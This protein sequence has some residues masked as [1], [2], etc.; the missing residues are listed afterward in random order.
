MEIE[1]IYRNYHDKVYSYIRSRVNS[2]EDAEDICSNVFLKIQTRSEEYEKD[3]GAVSTW[4]YAITKNAVIDYYRVHR[5]SEELPEEIVSDDEL[6]RDLLQKE[7]LQ[8]LSEALGHLSEEERD[9]IIL[10]Y[11]DNLSLRDIEK[12]TGMSYGQVKLRHNSA[13][14][15]MKK[16]F[17]KKSASGRFSSYQ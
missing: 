8:E 1:E 14:K 6:D 4:I 2:A 10:H 9:V 7:T 3:K 11:Y 17:L 12:K 5:I 16:F 13:L 15:E